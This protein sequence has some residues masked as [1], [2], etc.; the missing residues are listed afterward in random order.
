M[1]S[2]R[3]LVFITLHG[4]I[5]RNS[6]RSPLDVMRLQ[7]NENI[8]KLINDGKFSAGIS[9]SISISVECASLSFECV[10]PL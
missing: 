7:Q 1:N 9:L 2:N 3:E 8:N 6:V 5:A 10:V 4:H